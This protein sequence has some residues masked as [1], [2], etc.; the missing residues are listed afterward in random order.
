MIE[1]KLIRRVDENGERP[2]FFGTTVQLLQRSGDVSRADG[3]HAFEPARKSRAV[4][5]HPA[6]IGFIDRRF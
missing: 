1:W 3:D 5:R 4:I 6:V 2:I